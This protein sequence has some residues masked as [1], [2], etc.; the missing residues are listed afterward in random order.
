MSTRLPR[1]RALSSSGRQRLAAV[2]LLLSAIYFLVQVV[3]AARWPAE[4]PYDWSRNTISDLGVPECL[5][6]M[7]RFGNGPMS[8]RSICSPW[9]PLM[10][11][12]FVL[13]GLLFA[14]AAAC[15]RPLIPRRWGASLLLLA[16]ANAVGS[17]LV[18]AFPGSAD[19]FP[20]GRADR[21]LLHPLGA[22]LAG[23][24]GLILMVMV[25]IAC[26][27]WAPGRA[28]G[29]TA[30]F[31]ALVSLVALSAILVRADVGLGPGTLERLAVDPFIWWRT[32]A[33]ALILA[34]SVTRR[35]LTAATA[36][37]QS[38]PPPSSD[39]SWCA[40]REPGDVERA[41]CRHAFR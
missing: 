13:G 25:A 22:Y 11:A 32:L 17:M 19:E 3:V 37:P 4:H 9:H 7:S 18:G 16:G 23:V 24:S 41:S 5:G 35:R 2:L 26:R 39:R 14:G 28:L 10:N 20:S 31:F 34:G 38:V 12:A 40:G 27:R 8:D 21:V 6:D 1:A 29:I 33:G 15:V 30:A 36:V